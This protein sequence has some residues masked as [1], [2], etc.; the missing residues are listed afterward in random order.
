MIQL[1]IEAIL[2]KKSPRNTVFSPMQQPRRTSL[3]VRLREVANLYVS[4]AE[5]LSHGT[6]YGMRFRNEINQFE[7]RRDDHRLYL[8]H[9]PEGRSDLLG[10]PKEVF[11][12]LCFFTK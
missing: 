9:L 5:N 10:G 6:A 12:G 4:K 11:R 3:Q 1:L 7:T 8:C 2:G